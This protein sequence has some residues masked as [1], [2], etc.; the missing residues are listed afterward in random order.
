MKFTRLQSHNVWLFSGVE[1]WCRSLALGA[2]VLL[3]GAGWCM[4]LVQEEALV[5]ACACTQPSSQTLQSHEW[6]PFSLFTLQIN[7][8]QRHCVARSGY[9]A[10]VVRQ[11]SS[12][13]STLASLL[14]LASVTVRE[15]CQLVTA[16]TAII[17]IPRPST[18]DFDF[19]RLKLLTLNGFKFLLIFLF[20]CDCVLFLHFKQEASGGRRSGNC[21]ELLKNKKLGNIDHSWNQHLEQGILNTT[22]NTSIVV[23]F[24]ILIK[25][26]SYCICVAANFVLLCV[27]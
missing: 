16:G 19:Q 10:S 17:F 5:Q 7:L 8:S 9:K 1:L 2:L 12:S 3:F 20:L 27:F 23:I 24:G 18:N 14:K 6:R 22:N 13:L 21:M 11:A 25:F 26:G 4:A 15:H